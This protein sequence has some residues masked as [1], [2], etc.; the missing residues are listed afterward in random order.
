VEAG[1]LVKGYYNFIYQPIF[2]QSKNVEGILIFGYEITEMIEARN[3]VEETEQRSRLAIEAAN[4]G[5]FDWDMENN[6]FVSSPR[7][8][9][10]FGFQRIDGVTHMDLINRFHPEDKPIRD[11][12][13][14][15]SYAKGSLAYEARIVCP[16]GSIRWLNVYGKIIHSGSKGIAEDVWY[17][18]WML[19]SNER[20]CRS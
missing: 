12:A 9:E 17:R 20:S 2:N 3:K 14:E 10:I 1:N 11:K 4:I 15:E 6:I 13:V 18:P 7:L 16:D 5:T 19:R 8:I